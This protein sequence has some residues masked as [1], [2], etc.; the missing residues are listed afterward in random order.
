MARTTSEYTKGTQA[1]KMN[2]TF[3]DSSMPNHRMVSG[4]SAATGRFRPKSAIGAP[5]A[6]IARH[7]AATMPSGTPTRIA[8]P[9]PISTRL[10]RCGDALQQCPLVEQARGS[11]ASTSRRARQNHRRDD[12]VLRVHHRWWRA[13]RAERRTP[14][15]PRRA[16][17][18]PSAAAGR[19]AR[20][21]AAWLRAPST[22]RSSPQPDRP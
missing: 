14:P 20:T 5:A 22:W 17:G 7:D 1:M 2:I 10:Q 16:A 11:C 12:A 21:A 15:S 3:C 6:S 4:I 13:T 8:R 19:E 18:A 9:N